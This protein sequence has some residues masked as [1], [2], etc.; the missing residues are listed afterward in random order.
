MRRITFE[1]ALRVKNDKDIIIKSPH[2]KEFVKKKRK[3]K[4]FNLLEL[5]A[6][7]VPCTMKTINAMIKKFFNEIDYIEIMSNAE[8]YLIDY[9]KVDFIMED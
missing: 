3:E 8:F 4:D 1:K 9:D 7:E 6:D 5:I 2:L